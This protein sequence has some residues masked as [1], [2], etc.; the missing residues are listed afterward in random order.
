MQQLKDGLVAFCAVRSA[1]TRVTGG[2]NDHRAPASS[3]EQPTG[4]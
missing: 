4:G 2:T 3:K 1:I